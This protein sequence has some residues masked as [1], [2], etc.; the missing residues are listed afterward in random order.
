MASS[1]VLLNF[2][3]DIGRSRVARIPL[4]MYEQLLR[5]AE[6][7]EREQRGRRTRPDPTDGGYYREPKFERP[8][9][10]NGGN[11]DYDFIRDMFN[12]WKRGNGEQPK[13]GRGN[14][15]TRTEAPPTTFTRVTK[16]AR[17]F[18]FAGVEYEGNNNPEILERVLRKAKRKC[19]P[20]TG[21]SN[22]LWLE[23]EELAKWLALKF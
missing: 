15:N 18:E 8:A 11:P 23:L 2:I 9:S 16:I 12:D 19:H 21:G 6:D 13:P 5:A 20:D 1:F 10:H 4:G 7:L 14:T 3:D 22:E 17:L